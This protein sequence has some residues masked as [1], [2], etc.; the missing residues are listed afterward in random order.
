MTQHI[1]ASTEPGSL[2][3][4]RKLFRQHSKAYRLRIDHARKQVQVDGRWSK[5]DS[6]SLG[7]VPS[8]AADF[9][10]AQ[11][12]IAGEIGFWHLIRMLLNSL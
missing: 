8:G 11:G 9:T 7:L 6:F 12:L 3:W 1:A 10:R 2:P 4:F 5:H